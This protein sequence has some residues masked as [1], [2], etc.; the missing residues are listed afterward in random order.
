MK[1]LQ[2]CKNTA[3]STSIINNNISFVIVFVY[4]SFSNPT[5]NRH[6][7]CLDRTFCS[8]RLLLLFLLLLGIQSSN[9]KSICMNKYGPNWFFFHWPE[10][11]RKVVRFR[12]FYFDDKYFFSSIRILYIS[13]TT[14]AQF[15]HSN[16]FEMDQI[17][18]F[19]LQ[20]RN[21][22]FILAQYGFF[23]FDLFAEGWGVKERKAK[24]E[25]FQTN[26]GPLKKLRG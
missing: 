23:S 7:F 16:E 12:S 4:F 20:C 6:S 11:C 24:F 15:N 3:Q 9:S 13:F 1:I 14:S 25:R 21:F 10:D 5:R 22:L 26:K 19:P 8:R 2:Q 18:L 17:S